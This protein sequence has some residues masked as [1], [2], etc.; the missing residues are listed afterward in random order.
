MKT[1]SFQN[2]SG[3]TLALVIITMA[4]LIV[5]VVAATEYTTTVN[6]H[7]NR[8]NTYE[9]ALAVGDS[10]MEI[11]YAN[12]R[13]TCRAIPSSSPPPTSNSFSAIPTPSPGQFP[14]LPGSSVTAPFV[15]RGTNPDPDNGSDNDATYTISN[16]KVL[17]VSPEFTA[18]PAATPG[19]ASTPIPS[20]SAAPLPILGQSQ[21]ILPTAGGSGVYNYIASADITLP[22]LGGRASG[23]SGNG[24]VVAKVR[25]VFQKQQVSTLD[26]AI[27]YVDPLEIHPGP[28]FIV[29]GWVHSN[30]DLWTGH[31]TLTFG[32]KVT[33]G[34]NWNVDF[35]RDA[36]G[37]LIDLTHPETPTTP[38]FPLGMPPAHVDPFELPT[39]GTISNANSANGYH[40]IIEPPVTGIADPYASQRYWDEAGIIVQVTDNPSSST[41]G[42]DGVNGHDLVKFYTVNSSTGV[43]TRITSGAL[44][45]AFAASGVITTNQT[46]QDN[47]EGATTRV[48]SLDVSKL[49]TS[50]ATGNPNYLPGFPAANPI[51]Y[52]YNSSAGSTS[53]TSRAIRIR[54][55]SKIPTA[56]LTVASNNPVYIQGDFNTGRGYDTNGNGTPNNGVNPPSNISSN[57]NSNGTYP[58]PA[59]PPAPQVSGYNRAPASI[60]AD[61][62]NILS[63]NWKDNNSNASLSSRQANP[64]TINAAIVSGIVPT[65]AYGDGDYS[66]GAENFPRFLEDWSNT[67]LNYYGSMVELYQSKQAI[68]EWHYGGN[69]YIAPARNWFY[70]INFRTARPPGSTLTTLVTYTKGRWTVQ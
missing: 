15:K 58:D 16:Y 64:T 18:L 20:L 70:D 39:I 19:A 23:G 52:I 29:D 48:A 49:V 25:R 3:S 17:A 33:F 1:K 61:A 8:A 68:G 51:I 67:P 38:S 22:A 32:D 30:S 10:C 6:R 57:L 42:Y 55:G 14:T 26:F 50:P 36:N 37:T 35:M 69:I 21:S 63:N 9:I 12:W 47:R 7:V 31:D 2:Q 54:N 40:E 60:L 27:F 13:T 4:L 44:Y 56:G 62:V 45:N 43:T 5:I 24:N 28:Q 59:N 46:I 11:L 41:P 66:G 34:S 65:N 53:S